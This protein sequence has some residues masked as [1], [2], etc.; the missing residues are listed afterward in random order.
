[1]ETSIDNKT[2]I[3][4]VPKIDTKRFK[5]LVKLM[6][7]TISEKAMLYDPE[8]DQPL[9]DETMRVIEKARRGVDVTSYDSFDDFAKAMRA[10]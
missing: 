5:G 8:T 4:S 9:N 6:G 10:L 3:V 7:W 1:M 2:F